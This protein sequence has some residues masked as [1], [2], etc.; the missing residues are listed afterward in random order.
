MSKTRDSA[1]DLLLRVCYVL[2]NFFLGLAVSPEDGS[3]N[4]LFVL[5]IGDNGKGPCE[6]R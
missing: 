4:L 2:V 5:N 1:S 3:R 6:Y